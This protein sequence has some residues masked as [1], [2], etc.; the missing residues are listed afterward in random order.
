MLKIINNNQSEP[1]TSY[2]FVLVFSLKY[3]NFKNKREVWG[4]ANIP[5]KWTT[6]NVDENIIVDKWD[7]E[8]VAKGIELQWDAVFPWDKE[9]GY[10][11]DK[12]IDNK[13]HLVGIYNN[14]SHKYKWIDGDKLVDDYMGIYFTTLTKINYKC[15]N[16]NPIRFRL[17]TVL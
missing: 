9:E 16:T 2:E 13:F 1:N 12:L 14:I 17:M 8:L 3:K 5:I 15:E 11:R 7:E 6:E 10:M 4:R